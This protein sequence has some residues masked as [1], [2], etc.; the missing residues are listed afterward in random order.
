MIKMKSKVRGEST[1]NILK[2]YLSYILLI[3]NIVFF[4]QSFRV[5]GNHVPNLRIFFNAEAQRSQRFAEM[6]G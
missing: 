6:N 5:A 2:I 3:C 1:G 4:G